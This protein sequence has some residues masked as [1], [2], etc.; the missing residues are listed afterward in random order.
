MTDDRDPFVVFCTETNAVIDHVRSGED[1]AAACARLAEYGTSL[2]VLPLSLAW[3][4][5]EDAHRTPP[6][7]V[8]AAHYDDMLNILPPVAWTRDANG[9]SFK[10]SERLTGMVTA[11]YVNLNDRFFTF[12]DNIRMPHA[13]CCRVVRFSEAYLRPGRDSDDDERGG[14]AE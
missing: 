13:E 1:H 14:R 12:N 2:T 3:K 10:M 7:E 6:S 4:R 11:I 9:E 8:T 5:H